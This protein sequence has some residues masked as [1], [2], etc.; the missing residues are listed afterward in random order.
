MNRTTVDFNLPKT[1]SKIALINGDLVNKCSAFDNILQAQMYGAIGAVI[2]GKDILNEN[3]IM[4]NLFWEKKR[5]GIV[6]YRVNLFSLNFNKFVRI[7]TFRNKYN[8][9][10][11]PR[12]CSCR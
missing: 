6:I 9:S 11:V 5:G 3:S 7:G 1:I 2:Y 10:C 8:Y 4:V 12:G